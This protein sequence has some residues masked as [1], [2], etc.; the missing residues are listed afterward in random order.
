ME[1]KEGGYRQA[2]GARLR[3]ER[4]RLGYT[5]QQLADFGGVRKQ[6]QLNYEAGQTSPTAEYLALIQAQG[7]DVQFVIDGE[8]SSKLAGDE[9]EL[10]RRYRNS[11]PE[12][13]AAVLG[14]LGV[15]AV[16]TPSGVQI[17]NAS[18]VITGGDV[19]QSNARFHISDGKKK[20]SPK[21]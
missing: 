15:L 9:S 13:R 1:Y 2:S 7:I 10:L 11:S 4:K 5:Q 19:N 8:P 16:P 12:V 18:Q 21:Q 3:Q 20:R 14:A 17:G 6:A